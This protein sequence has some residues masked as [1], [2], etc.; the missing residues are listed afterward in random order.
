M[1]QIFLRWASSVFLIAL[2]SAS[3]MAQIPSDTQAPMST[4]A[5]ELDQVL[6]TGEQP[7]PGLW[8]V[9]KDDH[10]LWILGTLAPLPQKM[11]SDFFAD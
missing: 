9:S 6:V 5:T 7:G 3:V 4:Q 11:S 8:K 1:K 10:V 2:W